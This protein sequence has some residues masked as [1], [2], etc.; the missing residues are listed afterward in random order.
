MPYDPLFSPPHLARGVQFLRFS[1]K[2]PVLKCNH[3]LR[4]HQDPLNLSLADCAHYRKEM[5][6][7]TREG[8]F[9]VREDSDEGGATGN[10]IVYDGDFRWPLNKIHRHGNRVVVIFGFWTLAR[11][12]PCR[13][14]DG[15]TAPEA[16]KNLPTKP[17]LK[18]RLA[19]SVRWPQGARLL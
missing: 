13:F 4:W 1:N 9:Q 18:K 5:D 2:L 17:F 19:N 11:R 15:F 16:G 3:A 12:C 8:L 7:N 14:L 6:G 10:Y